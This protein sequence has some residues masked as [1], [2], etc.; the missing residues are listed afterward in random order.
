MANLFHYG[1]GKNDNDKCRFIY[2]QGYGITILY[3]SQEIDYLVIFRFGKIYKE[4]N[5]EIY[6]YNFG[7]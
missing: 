4:T 3:M 5:L 6:I 1:H 2:L 7:N